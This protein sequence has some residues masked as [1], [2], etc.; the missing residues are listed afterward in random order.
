MNSKIRTEYKQILHKIE[1]V[2]KDFDTTQSDNLMKII[3]MTK[4]KNLFNCL[5]YWDKFKPNADRPYSILNTDRESDPGNGTHWVGTFQDDKVLYIYDSFGRKNIMNRFC[6]E[7]HELGFR[8]VLVNKKSDQ[9]NKQINCGLRS[10]LWLLFVEKY[11]I[12][13]ASKI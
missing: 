1:D 7:I 12:K 4:L 2:C 9:Q 8:C 10:L 11:G 13:Q 3:N 6:D 5:D